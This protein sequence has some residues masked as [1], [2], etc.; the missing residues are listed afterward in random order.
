MEVGE[1]HNKRGAAKGL[2]QI[3]RGNRTEKQ[4]QCEVQESVNEK[5]WEDEK[6]GGNEN[7]NGNAIE[8][9]NENKSENE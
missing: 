5:A 1:V 3:E 4:L 6:K 9:G 8:K 2:N 7:G